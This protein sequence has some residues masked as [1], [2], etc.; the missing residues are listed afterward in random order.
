MPLNISTTHGLGN[1]IMDRPV[2]LQRTV[3]IWGKAVMSWA[4]SKG[5]LRRRAPYSMVDLDMGFKEYFDEWDQDGCE[6]E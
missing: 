3:A 2:S 1:I 5:R 4:W 6:P